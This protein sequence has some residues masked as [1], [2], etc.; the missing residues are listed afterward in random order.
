MDIE[1]RTPARRAFLALLATTPWL[2]ACS[3]PRNYRYRLT[4][5]VE[6]NGE[7]FRGAAVQEIRMARPP[8]FLAQLDAGSLAIRGEAPVIDFGDARLL[9]PTLVGVSSAGTADDPQWNGSPW[10]PPYSFLESSTR[11]YDL[12]AI[13]LPLLVTF[14]D[15]GD[16]NTVE[17]VNPTKLPRRFG[18]GARVRA[19]RLEKTRDPITRGEI[20]RRLPWLETIHSQGVRLDGSEAGSEFAKNKAASRLNAE[21]FTRSET[22]R[23]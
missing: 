11:T 10:S 15:P 13:Y 7:V 23:R 9:I 18:A 19:V 5:E 20:S 4:V 12:D 8:E 16:P 3:I 2:S 14:S 1:H 21:A 6:A 17:T 22:S